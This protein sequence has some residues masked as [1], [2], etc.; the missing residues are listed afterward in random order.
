MN[1]HHSSRWVTG[2]TF[3][4]VLILSGCHKKVVP[5]PA[6]ALP[7]PPPAPTARITANPQ[8]I[9]SGQS[10]ILSWTTANSD[11][12]TISGLGSVGPNGSRSVAPARSTEY[13]V[14]ATGADGASIQATA[15]VTVNQ[16]VAVTAPPP[17]PGPTMT[18]EQLFAQ[19]VRDVYFDYDKYALRSTDE[20]TAERDASFLKSHPA[21]KVLIEGHCDDRGSEE[22]NLALGENRAQSL[23]EALVENGVDASRVKVISDGEEKPFCGEENES[24]WQENRRDH[25]TLDRQAQ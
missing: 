9:D 8:V 24:C 2:A 6:A 22:Y 18:E 10:T 19:N 14:T 12:V 20:T 15:R 7:P 4:A 3:A 13:T 17:A 23:K 5:P 16:P 21:M 25:L 1:I 11:K